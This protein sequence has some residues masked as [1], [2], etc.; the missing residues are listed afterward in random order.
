VYVPE[1]FS[2]TRLEVLQA[3][4]ERHPLA[5]LVAMTA[6]GLTAN[7][8][9]VR[10]Q[11]RAGGTGLLQGHIARANPL[12]RALERGA[13][14]LAVFTGADTYVSPAWYPSK[15]EHGKV[16]PTWNYAAVHVR[17]RIR[18]VEEA[19]WLRGLVGSLTDEHERGGS[20]PWRVSDAPADYI[21]AMLRAIVGFEIE[22]SEVVGK[23]KGS[24]NRPAAD[25]AAVREALRG[26]GRSADEIAELVSEPGVS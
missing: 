18:F 8:V 11:L 6:A 12:W 4:I 7:H 1:H 25:R 16:V 17:G 19:A 3:F 26:A 15:R 9:P 2:E 13:T 24:Q 20:P 10:A 14:V 21:E 5:T 22:I 23:F